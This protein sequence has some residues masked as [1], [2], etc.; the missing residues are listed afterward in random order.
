M[1]KSNVFKKFSLAAVISLFL[2]G[3]LQGSSGWYSWYPV[4]RNVW[5]QDRSDLKVDKRVDFGRLKNGL[6]YAIMKNNEPPTKVSMRLL[7]ESGSFMEEED[8]RGLAHFL[9]HMAFNGSKSFSKREFIE[10][11]QRIGMA[12][13]P[14]TNAYTTFNRTVYMLDLPDNQGATMATGLKVLREI[15]DSLTLDKEAMEVERGVVYSELRDGLSPEKK[16]MDAQYSFFLDGT[17]VPNRLP[18]GLGEVILKTPRERLEAFYK[19]WYTVDRMVVVVVGDVKAEEVEKL[20]EAAFGDMI[21][22][23]YLDFPKIGKVKAEGMKAEVYK[24]KALSKTEVEIMVVSNSPE[25]YKDS[26]AERIKSMRR[27][28]AY[29]I[30][31]KRFDILQREVNAPFYGVYAYYTNAFNKYDLNSV[32]LNCKAPHWKAALST[33]EQEIRRALTFGFTEAEFQE[34][35]KNLINGLEQAVLNEPTYKNPMLAGSLVDSISHDD[36]FTDATYY[37][38]L[39]KTAMDGFTR[40][41]CH[42]LFK[43]EWEG[44]SP[45]LFLSGNDELEASKEELIQVYKESQKVNVSAPKVEEVKKFAYNDFGKAGKYEEVFVDKELNLHG[46]KFENNVR[47]TLMPTEYEKGSISINVN[48]GNGSRL[49]NKDNDGI[50]TVARAVFIGGGLELHKWSEIDSIFAGKTMGEGFSI[51]ADAFALSG[52]T[53]EKDLSDQMKLLAAYMKYPEFRESEFLV[54]RKHFEDFYNQMYKTPEG[55]YGSL[56]DKYLANNNFRFGVP[57]KEKVMSFTRDDVKAWLDGALKHGYTEITIVGDFKIETALKAVAETFGAMEKREEA[58]DLTLLEGVDF[59][60]SQEA[61]EFYVD[62]EIQ[63]GMAT[64][65]WKTTD[66]WNI[67]TSR[68][69]SLLGMIFTDRLSK[70]I[71]EKYGDAYSPFAYNDPNHLH[72]GYGRFIAMANVAPEKAQNVNDLI[73]QIASDLAKGNISEDEFER[74]QKPLLENVKKQERSNAYWIGQLNE[75][76]ARPQMLSLAKDKYKM[77]A[78]FTLQDIKNIAKEYL[79]ADKAYPVVIVPNNYAKQDDASSEELVGAGAEAAF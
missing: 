74:A 69:L 10:Y 15:G 68:K 77:Y 32:G 36:V 19:K 41:D 39:G 5:P 50:E 34:A 8:Q 12:F 14:D 3:L 65:T 17:L 23:P 70:E 71:R 13:G 78:G 51:D 26:K 79:E 21:K 40:E 55:I 76:Q 33:A 66:F 60:E 2:L 52:K 72:K 31:S 9:E 59:P 29:R 48:F 61:K 49:I 46:Y 67:E 30:I 11:F 38:S 56:V 35:Q 75:V 27:N 57:D 63:K 16:L 22:G 44:K 47:L 53:T 25:N 64:V 58:K 62:S 6:R 73:M 1:T 43:S 4:K 20:I 37:L 24:D 42:K 18:I 54:A 28:L 45:L 7:V